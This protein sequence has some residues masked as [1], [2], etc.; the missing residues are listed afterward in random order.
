MEGGSY[1]E[2]AWERGE[3]RKGIYVEMAWAAGRCEEIAYLVGVRSGEI[4]TIMMEGAPHVVV[5]QRAAILVLAEALK[6][7]LDLGPIDYRLERCGRR[8]GCARAQACVPDATVWVVI[9]VVVLLCVVIRPSCVT[10]T[11]RDESK[12]RA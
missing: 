6:A 4:D 11:G 5:A 9:K 2:M 8:L 7:L 1:E 10:N 12:H 3:I